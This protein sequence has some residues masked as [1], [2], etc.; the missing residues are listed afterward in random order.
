M[1]QKKEVYNPPFSHRLLAGGIAGTCE[2]LVMYPTDVVKTRA[3]L[4]VGKDKQGMVSM[5]YGIYK[6]EGFFRLYRGI[7]PPILVEAPKRAVK[8]AANETYKPFFTGKDGK[9]GQ[10]GAIGAGVSAGI[11]EAFVV[12][13]FELVKIRL[14]DKANQGRYKN[15]VDA[16]TKIFQSEGPFAFFKGLESTLWRHAMW[17]GGYFGTIFYVKDK[18]PKPKTEQ[19][20]LFVNFVAGALSGTFGTILNTPYD[21]VKSRIQNQVSEPK[22]YN[23]TIPALGTIAKEE[24]FTAL[25]KGFVPKV[26]RLGPGGGI[27]LVVFEYVSKKLKAWDMERKGY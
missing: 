8:F 22:K 20:N 1:A 13:P 12:V 3:Q 16:I 26:V 7:L 25:Y 5:L 4:S 23:W 10:G 11:T 21:V 27:L 19:G 15:T 6:Q 18:L 2:I 17:N 14:Q 24:G 9:L